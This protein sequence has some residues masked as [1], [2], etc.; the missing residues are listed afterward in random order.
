MRG[1]KRAGLPRKH[2]QRLAA[3]IPLFVDTALSFAERIEINLAKLR[4]DHRVLK[5][6]RRRIAGAGKRQRA[7]V[8]LRKRTSPTFGYDWT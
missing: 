1:P 8:S 4:Q 5:L 7:R 6:A 2:G 3:A